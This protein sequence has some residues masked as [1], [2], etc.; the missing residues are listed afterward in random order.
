MPKLIYLEDMKSE[1]KDL[2]K[3]Y[4]ELTEELKE[5]PGNCYAQENWDRR[6][7]VII[8]IKKLT[9]LIK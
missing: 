3:E 2:E 6:L 1:I 4:N 8:R 5:Y 7:E 9:E